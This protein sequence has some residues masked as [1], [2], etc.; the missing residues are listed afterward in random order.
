MTARVALVL[1]LAALALTG[2]M[3]GNQ[4]RSNAAPSAA[5]I[6]Q[7]AEL[8]TLRD[9]NARLKH[10]LDEARARLE[11]GSSAAAP[12]V[13]SESGAISGGDIEGFER[14][15][16]G[17][18]A[19][20]DDLAFAKGSAT[21]TDAGEQAIAR[22]AKRLNEGDNAGKPVTVSGHTDRTPVARPATKEKF[23][24]NWGLSAARSAAVVRALEKA[25]VAA[26]RLHGAFRGEHAPRADAKA[27][28]K[29][30]DSAADRRV[31]ITL[32]S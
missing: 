29:S 23:S 8:E 25:G 13:A 6:N 22:L 19:L 17:G 3:R 21:L 31:E 30:K 15:A 20:P 18:V 1:P 7:T 24:D 28:A 10:Q 12:T 11:Q 16:N 2:C 4:P 26:S 32:G 27:D 9:D 14:T 5:N